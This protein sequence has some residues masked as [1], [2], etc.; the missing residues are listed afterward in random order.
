M[1]N[2]A[3]YKSKRPT[4]DGRQYF[5][6]IKYKDIRGITHDYTSQKYKTQKEAVNEEATYRIK[7]QKKE[8]NTS[9][10]TLKQIFNEFIIDKSNVVKKQTIIKLNIQFTHFKAIEDCKINDLTLQK[11]K[12]WLIEFEKEGLAVAYYNKLLGLL[13]QLISYSNKM[14]NTSDTILKFI[15]NKKNVNALKK[16]MDFYTLDEYKTF[17]SAISDFEWHVFFEILYYLGIRQGEIQALNWHDIDLDKGL[18]S[19]NKTLT[20]KIKG[21]NWT[22][23]TPKTKSS[24]R[25]LPMPKKVLEDVNK[26]KSEKMKYT[27]YSDDWF[28]F[29]NSVP[30]KESTIQKKKN[31]CCDIIGLRRIRIHDF[32][33][34][35]ASL[36]INNGASIAL[37][38]KYLGHSN[39]SITLN[40][41]T[42]MYKSELE[43]I[44][45]LLNNL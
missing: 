44:T 37:V 43:S 36:L 6:R 30:F 5:F 22:I 8:T 45:N 7:V 2:M 12:L 27:D 3:V 28:V 31:D 20:S 35:C 14:Y 13:R 40:T 16:E 4:K 33:H 39:I 1:I 9:N 18:L 32:R 15:E 23:S 41:Y 19:I 10:I 11:Y 26:L 17:D 25:V 38:S 42:H 34:S 21:E 24:I 29:G